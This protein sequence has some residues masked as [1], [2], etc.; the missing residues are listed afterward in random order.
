VG[1]RGK[2]AGDGMDKFGEGCCTFVN[3]R[4]LNKLIFVLPHHI[5]FCVHCVSA[6]GE[7]YPEFLRTPTNG[8]KTAVELRDKDGKSL[9]WKVTLS[10]KAGYTFY[11]QPGGELVYTCDPFQDFH[12][13]PLGDYVP[14]CV[15]E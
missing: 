7:C 9:G 13:D 15:G 6:A 12:N 10:C 11:G 3:L 4:P 2:W 1:W 8:Q 5:T 14:D